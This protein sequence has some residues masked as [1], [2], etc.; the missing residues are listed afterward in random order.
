MSR[1]LTDQRISCETPPPPRGDAPGPPPPEAY[2]ARRRKRWLVSCIRLLG[3]ANSRL[4][5]R[6]DAEDVE[7]VAVRVAEVAR[8]ETRCATRPRCPLVGRSQ[9]DCLLV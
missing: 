1:R 5:V 9:L 7:L 3:G 8:V 4:I 6:L 2:H